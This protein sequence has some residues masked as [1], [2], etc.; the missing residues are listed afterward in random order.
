MDRLSAI[1]SR[2]TPTIRVFYSGHSCQQAVFDSSESIG[3]IHILK[4]GCMSLTLPNDEQ[5]VVDQPSVIFYPRPASHQ[6]ESC[7]ELELELL[8]ASIYLGSAA[9][10][11]L[12]EA[13]PACLVLPLA[14][15]EGL[16]PM[17][18]VL[19]YEA[20][21]E[22]CGRQVALDHL[23][24]YVL[25]LLLR[26]VIDAG[27]YSVGV[28]AGLSDVK[29]SKALTAVHEN[30]AYQW[31]LERLAGV[32]GMSRARF[33]AHFKAAIGSTPMDYVSRWRMGVAQSLLKQGYS[34][35]QVAPKVGYQ[36]AAA[37]TR[38]FTS[39][40]GLPP[41]EWLKQ[42]REQGSLPEIKDLDSYIPLSANG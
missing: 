28:L 29:L 21:E 10:N 33:A 32:A 37:M 36:S 13:L 5:I 42:V 31:T 16:E 9:S 14:K 3:Y 39:R 7:S 38:T 8:C 11:P 35:K 20:S 15:L 34:I 1:F 41:S 23:V 25:V 27:N 6:F 24:G 30:P 26:H 2:F 22:F 19:F 17:L 40:F 12:C 4:S 18:D